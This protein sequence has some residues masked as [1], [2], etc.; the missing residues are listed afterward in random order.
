V[1]KAERERRLAE[2]RARDAVERPSRGTYF[3]RWLWMEA[4]GDRLVSPRDI[5]RVNA[6]MIDYMA[7]RG[8]H[9]ALEAEEG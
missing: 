9:S 2:A 6:T 1:P 3:W 8:I 7:K 5:L 4:D